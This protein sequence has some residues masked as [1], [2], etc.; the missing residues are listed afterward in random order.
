MGDE[1]ARG[2]AAG[3]YER[4]AASYDHNW[5]YNPGHIAWMIGRIVEHGVIR[6][7]DVV[8]DIGCGT[9]L[10]S[11]GLAAVSGQVICIDPSRSMLD[12]VPAD[13]RLVPVLASAQD[14]VSGL[15]ALPVAGLDVIVM[16]EAVH[17][18]PPAERAGTLRGMA[19]LLRPGGRIVIVTLPTRIGY[20][21]FGA[22]LEK[23][24]RNQPDPDDVTAMLVATGLETRIT[25]DEYELAIPKARYL[26]M[27]RDRYMSLLSAF[28]DD[29]IEHGIAEIGHLHPEKV[30]E[31]TDR[32]AFIRGVR[33]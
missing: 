1:A 25:Y 3:H 32:F 15:A 17:H 24:T 9:G 20:P 2:G 16:K 30:L 26:A 18:V 11:R 27:V 13:A 10:Y 22:A 19:G 31:F 12:Q 21:L 28:T 5:T 8:A 7:G 29:E 33:A 6:D 23:F 14:I 4:L